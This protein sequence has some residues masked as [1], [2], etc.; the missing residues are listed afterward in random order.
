MKTNQIEIKASVKVYESLKQLSKADQELLKKAEEAA[1]FSFSPYS[2]FPVGAALLLEN[3]EYI[4]GSNQENASF[5]VGICAER[6]ALSNLA[7]QAPKVAIDTLTI[8]VPAKE[9]AAPCGICRQSLY[10]QEFKQKTPIRMLLKGSGE[11]VYELESVESILPLP[12]SL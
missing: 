10:Q 7:M 5:P 11:T 2:E 12:F 6:V 3:G 9:I 4:L 8:T 1:T